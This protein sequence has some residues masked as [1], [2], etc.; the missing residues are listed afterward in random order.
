MQA[1]TVLFLKSKILKMLTR[2]QLLTRTNTDG[3]FI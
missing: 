3:Y 2:K 1:F